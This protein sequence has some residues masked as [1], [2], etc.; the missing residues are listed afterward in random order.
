MQHI[1][2]YHMIKLIKITIKDVKWAYTTDKH[3]LIFGIPL[4]QEWWRWHCYSHPDYLCLKIHQVTFDCSTLEGY[5]SKLKMIETNRFQILNPDILK[6]IYDEGE[7]LS[8]QVTYMCK[9]MCRSTV[10]FTNILPQH[11]KVLSIFYKFSPW[12]SI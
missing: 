1:C 8:V 11:I 3:S 12:F 5:I 6:I 7:N 4:L 2:R 10:L 9:E